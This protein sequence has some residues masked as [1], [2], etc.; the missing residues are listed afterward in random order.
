MSKII[1]VKFIS[2]PYEGK[3]FYFGSLAAIYEPF[4]R[5]N[6]IIHFTNKDTKVCWQV[7]SRFAPSVS[8]H[9]ENK[10]CII[11]VDE[12]IRK[13]SERGKYER[14]NVKSENKLKI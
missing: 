13:P 3:S 7:L 10:R 1:I 8:N 5:D 6:Q 9:Y 11:S 12:L 2:G 4:E 14:G